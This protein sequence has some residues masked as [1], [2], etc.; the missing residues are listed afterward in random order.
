MVGSGILLSEEVSGCPWLDASASDMGSAASSSSSGL[1][2]HR[3]GA[4]V[5]SLSIS[6]LLEITY[7]LG[8]V[9]VYIL[10]IF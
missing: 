9:I 6:T 8:A 5:I 3:A 4:V 10:H 2:E 7:L 1:N